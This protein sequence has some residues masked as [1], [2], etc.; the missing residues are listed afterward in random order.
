M[1][2]VQQKQNNFF[3]MS[4]QQTKLTY[5]LINCVSSE[6]FKVTSSYILLDMIRVLSFLKKDLLLDNLSFFFQSLF[7]FW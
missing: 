6:P 5:K 1:T 7:F 4:H 2:L 3:K